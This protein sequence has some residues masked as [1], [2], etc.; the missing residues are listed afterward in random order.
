MAEMLKSSRYLNTDLLIKQQKR[1]PE[2]VRL[3]A[4][5]GPKNLFAQRDAH[6]ATSSC[7]TQWRTQF[8]T[9]LPEAKKRRR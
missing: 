5:G 3:I 8:S 7:M 6:N 4:A 9:F 1:T 2:K